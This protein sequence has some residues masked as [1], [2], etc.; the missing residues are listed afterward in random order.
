MWANGWSGMKRFTVVITVA[1]LQL[2]DEVPAL[3]GPF[4]EALDANIVNATHPL[5]GRRST[6]LVQHLLRLAVDRQPC[7]HRSSTTD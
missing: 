1:S 3:V 2:L 6:H 7:H 4:L 5:T